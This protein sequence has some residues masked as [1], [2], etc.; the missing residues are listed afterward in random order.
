MAVSSGNSIF[1][2]ARTLAT[3]TGQDPNQ[4]VS[5]DALG[6]LRASLNECIRTLY[7]TY[8]KDPKFLRD[9][10]TRNTVTITAGT[11]TCPDQIMRE[12]LPNVAQFQDDNSSL[13]SYWNFNIDY[14]SGVN[15]RQLGYVVLRNSTFLYT[16]PAPDYAT[17]SGSLFVTCPTFPTFPADMASDITFPSEETIDSLVTLLAEMILGNVRYDLVPYK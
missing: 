12:F 4:S 9:T 10:V 5:I 13:I 2:R 14:D 17:Y 15:F 16:A 8:C 11:G 1:A 7:R 3:M 6:G